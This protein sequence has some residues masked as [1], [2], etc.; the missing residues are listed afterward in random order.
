M[1]SYLRGGLIYEITSIRAYI[2]WLM[3]REGFNVG[4]NDIEARQPNKAE[5]ECH[6]GGGAILE[7]VSWKGNQDNVQVDHLGIG[8]RQPPGA[9]ST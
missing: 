9:H 5:A 1:G 4:F 2:R 3:T 7:I 8:K 6:P